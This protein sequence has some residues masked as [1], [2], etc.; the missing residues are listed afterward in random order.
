[1]SLAGALPKPPAA[2][3]IPTKALG[4]HQ[5]AMVATALPMVFRRVGPSNVTIKADTRSYS[6]EV[7][8][9]LETRMREVSEGLCRTH[10]YTGKR[11]TGD[12]DAIEALDG[13]V[14][15]TRC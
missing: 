1:L 6:P 5:A 7:Q 10:L 15:G 11:V 2:D 4:T 14:G 12:V 8:R 13:Y 3:A 9:L